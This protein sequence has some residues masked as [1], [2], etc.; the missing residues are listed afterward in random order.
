M[1]LKSAQDAQSLANTKRDQV[2]KTL[3][4]TEKLLA[5]AQENVK[6]PTEE[7]LTAQKLASSSQNNLN[8]WKAEQINLTRQ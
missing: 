6:G 3:E 7:L 1:A 4:E 8:R 5:Q 2:K